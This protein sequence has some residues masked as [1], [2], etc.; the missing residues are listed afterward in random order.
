[1]C[2]DKEELLAHLRCEEYKVNLIIKLCAAKTDKNESISPSFFVTRD[3]I[4][5]INAYSRFKRYGIEAI[6]P[7]GNCPNIVM[8]SFD[9]IQDTLDRLTQQKFPKKKA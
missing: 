5:L 8:Q 1:M 7:H 4:R 2:K 6:Y 3:S 9:V